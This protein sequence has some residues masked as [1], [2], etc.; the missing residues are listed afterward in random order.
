MRGDKPNHC[1]WLDQ[2]TQEIACLHCITIVQPHLVQVDTPVR[3][4]VLQVRNAMGWQGDHE[5]RLY[6][7]YL[8]CLK[9]RGD[10]RGRPQEHSLCNNRTRTLDPQEK[11]G[12]DDQRA[13]RR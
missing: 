4:R 2:S 8:F 9:C 6:R 3:V 1:S 5:D 7:L 11:G 10:P 13:D 12:C